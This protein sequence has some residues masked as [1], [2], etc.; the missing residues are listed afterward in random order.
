[1]AQIKRL[2]YCVN[3]EWLEEHPTIDDFREIFDRVLR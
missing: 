3:G 1:M 2:K